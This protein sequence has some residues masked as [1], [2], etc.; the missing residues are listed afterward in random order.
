[1]PTIQKEIDTLFSNF[2]QN[3]NLY[4]NTIINFQNDS[5]KFLN[6]TYYHPS[7][8][9]L[10]IASYLLLLEH[11]PANFIL[12]FTSVASITGVYLFEEGIVKGIN[13]I[14]HRKQQL[15]LKTQLH[16][17]AQKYEQYYNTI[18][19]S[20]IL[21]KKDIQLDTVVRHLRSQQFMLNDFLFFNLSKTSDNKKE[22]EQINTIIKKTLDIIKTYNATSVNA[23]ICIGE[24]IQNYETVYISRIFGNNQLEKI[25]WDNIS[26]NELK[27][28]LIS[29][30]IQKHLENNIDYIKRPF[31]RGNI[32]SQANAKLAKETRDKYT[33]SFLKELF[34]SRVLPKHQLADIFNICQT[35]L[36]K[37]QYEKIN[38]FAMTTKNKENTIAL[39]EEKQKNISINSEQVNLEDF[40]K[41]LN[42]NINIE[43]LIEHLNFIDNHNNTL[44]A[45]DSISYE[46]IKNNLHNT[47]PKIWKK[48]DNFNDLDKK[49]L[50]QQQIIASIYN[51]IDT[52]HQMRIN[53]EQQINKETRILNKMSMSQK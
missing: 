34:T 26:L 4:L 3:R 29:T 7:I 24:T 25:C 35:Y 15:D 37:D 52:I 1:M 44:S 36:D 40:F 21:D 28:Y 8:T 43:Q 23:N 32:L 10:S 47:Y 18:V 27:Q 33:M 39:N 14:K 41:H 51:N 12:S 46:N 6:K 45:V 2:I 48:L 42:L 9:A 13:A 5:K 50:S 22:V 53:I 20:I 38:T 49:H 11:T 19:K 17:L 30:N 31:M 16:S